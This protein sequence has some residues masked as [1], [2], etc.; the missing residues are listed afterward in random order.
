MVKNPSFSAENLDVIPGRGTN[1]PPATGQLSLHTTTTEPVQL[2][3]GHAT[4]TPEALVELHGLSS[5]GV[6]A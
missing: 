3:Q 2:N 5:C 6:Q 1:T 4:A